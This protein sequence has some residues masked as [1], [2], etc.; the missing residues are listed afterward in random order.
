MLINYSFV[1]QKLA[2]RVE[3]QQGA[4][5]PKEKIQKLNLFGYVNKCVHGINQIIIFCLEHVTQ[6]ERRD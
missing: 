3:Y 1:Q 4:R 2:T 5:V 6:K